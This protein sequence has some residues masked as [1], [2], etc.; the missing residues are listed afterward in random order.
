MKTLRNLILLNAVLL[1]GL[2]FG[3][4]I[5]H[6]HSFPVIH[7]QYQ[8]MSTIRVLGM[9]VGGFGIMLLMLGNFALI[10]ERRRIA[11][12]LSFVNALAA[13]MV[14]AQQ[15]GPVFVSPVG[16]ILLSIPAVM[17]AGLVWA[18]VR[19]LKPEEAAESLPIPDEVRRSWLRQIGEAAAQEERNRLARDLH[20]SIKQQLFTINVSTAAAQ[21]LW[22]RDPERARGALEDVR[23][24]AK[25]AMVEMQALLHQLGPQ[26]LAS[27]GLVEA[28]RE[29]CEALG[30]RTGAEVS[31][32]L[33][34]AIPDDRLP[35][36]AQET[37]FRIAQ[38]ALSNVA[39]HAR[40][41]NVRVWLGRES[42]TVKLSAEDDG[43]GFQPEQ[44][45]SGMGLRNLKERADSLRGN[46]AVTSAPG[47]GTM[48][49]VRIPL[50]PPPL[51]EAPVHK[52]I[53][54]ERNACMLLGVPALFFLFDTL[55]RDFPY[56]YVFYALFILTPLLLILLPL[57][58]SWWIGYRFLRSSSGV[59]L[60]SLSLLRYEVHRHRALCLFVAAW[61]APWHWNLEKGWTNVWLAVAGVCLLL[62]LL[63]LI[64]FHQVSRFTNPLRRSSPTGSRFAL[65]LLIGLIL[66]GT[67][68]WIFFA[69]VSLIDPEGTRLM[70]RSFEKTLQPI[71][72]KIS[73]LASATV[74]LLYTL[75]RE[76]RT[77]G[78]PS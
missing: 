8:E 62:S 2:G 58:T 75:F 37:L 38:E 45:L 54:R 60:Q 78:A 10:E 24:S 69:G 46:L 72:I 23:R 3:M 66:L 76:P 6:P 43:Q 57:V 35:P 29:Q 47:V 32:E 67:F 33:G 53:E 28:I 16:W 74:A 12:G 15:A 11:F 13:L 20:D 27:V 36:G 44:A 52:A 41:R 77:E 21:E 50:T 65:F 34:E 56:P 40:A 25:E 1:V 30:Y 26:A 70:I 73:F 9:L 31:M 14:L 7:K 71:P 4:A 68:S 22:E 42:E 63:E 18:G 61:W 55:P 19:P 59:P 64:N 17:G 5:V 39:R 48:I 51:P 49:E